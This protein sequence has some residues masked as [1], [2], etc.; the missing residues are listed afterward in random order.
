MGDN[1]DDSLDSRFAGR[2]RRDRHAAGRQSD[3]PRAGHLLVDRRL[4]VLVEALDLV[5]R[6]ARQPHRQRLYG[7]TPNERRRRRTSF[8]T[9]SATSRR[10]SPC[11]SAPSPMPATARTITSGSNSSATACSAC[12]RRTGSTSA[13]PNEPEGNLSRRYNVLVARE[14]CAEVGRE[15]GVPAQIRLGKQ[16]RDDGANESDNVVGDVV[17]ALIGALC[18]STA[19]SRRR[20]ASSA[21]PGAAPRRASA[22]RPSIPSPRCRNWPPPRAASRPL[23]EVVGRTGAAPRADLHVKVSVQGSAKRTPRARASRKPKPRRPR[24]C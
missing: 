5:H 14:T 10:T 18:C 6:A 11:S 22:R 19:G 21:R 13:I 16:A 7:A 1:R 20:S 17:E 4:R 3:R 12:H 15:L 9:S 23:Y 2:C 8:A 24:R